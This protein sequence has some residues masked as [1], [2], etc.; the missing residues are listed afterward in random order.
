MNNYLTACTGLV[1]MSEERTG[2]IFEN[3]LEPSAV[4]QWTLAMVEEFHAIILLLPF[5]KDK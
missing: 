1:K 5:V 3:Q 4:S 2:E